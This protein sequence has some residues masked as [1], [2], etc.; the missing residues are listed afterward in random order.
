MSVISNFYKRQMIDLKPWLFLTTVVFAFGFCI[1]IVLCI[2][3]PELIS[4]FADALKEITEKIS[5]DGKIQLTWQSAYF[6]FWQNFTAAMIVSFG[7]AIFGLPTIFVSFVNFA[8]LGFF[9]GL[10]IFGPEA[11][12]LNLF[13]FVILIVPH[14]I[15]EIAA[16]LLSVAL[17]LK[18][19]ILWILPK[20]KGRRME[21]FRLS[22]KQIFVMIPLIVL[23]LFLAATIEIFVTGNLSAFLR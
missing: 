17:G 3:A 16:I 6:V 7:G 5:K 23:L 12:Q 1:G 2:V 21:A 10:A 15:F 9:A 13:R 18:L 19:G 22:L 20:S 4:Y 8:L 11:G 14:G